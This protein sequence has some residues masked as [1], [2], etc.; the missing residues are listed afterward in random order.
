MTPGSVCFP[1]LSSRSPWRAR[2]CPAL[3][4]THASTMCRVPSRQHGTEINLVPAAAAAA[5]ATATAD[6]LF[7]LPSTCQAFISPPSLPADVWAEGAAGARGW[8]GGSPG[9]D[10]STALSVKGVR[11]QAEGPSSLCNVV[12]C[13]SWGC[14]LQQTEDSQGGESGDRLG[15]PSPA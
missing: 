14:C 4:V 3:Q 15:S 12:G 9:E 13:R 5:A 2:H 11:S 1:A 6:P 10:S 8:D 7:A